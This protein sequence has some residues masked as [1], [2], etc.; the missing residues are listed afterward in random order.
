MSMIS[1]VKSL[2]TSMHDLATE[3]TSNAGFR[4][5][6]KQISFLDGSI[7]LKKMYLVKPIFKKAPQL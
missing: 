3:A 5:T 4:R 1:T 2:S 7:F 6:P